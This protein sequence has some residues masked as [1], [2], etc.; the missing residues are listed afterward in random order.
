MKIIL[1]LLL[2]VPSM[3]NALEVDEKLTVRILKTSESRKTILINRGTEDGLVEGDH[4]R[5]MVTAG[6]VARGMVVKVSPSRSVWSI[7][8]LVNA[9]YIVNDSVMT[10]KITPPVKVTKDESQSLIREDVPTRTTPDSPPLGIPLADGANDLQTAGIDDDEDLRAL[11]AGG[12]S[13]RSLVERNMEVVGIVNISSLSSTSSA[14]G[15]DD[16]SGSMA[17][18]HIGATFEYYPQN[19]RAWYSRFSLLGSLNLIKS[20]AQSY[21]GFTAKNDYTEF[22]LGVNWHPTK[23]PSQVGEFIPFLTVGMGYGQVKSTVESTQ[24][25]SA[26]GTGNSFFIGGGYKFYARNGFGARI[27]LDY[28]LRSEVFDEDDETNQ[29]NRSLS[30][31][32]FQVGLSYRF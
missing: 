23:L 5:F 14:D 27:L 4:A 11:S 30:G 13:I 31:P 16:A 28:Y 1:M 24:E 20:D 26:T 25:I 6:I 22:G 12:G 2:L 15:Q 21:N 9:D 19:E 3:T 8:R 32:R 29:Y 17:Q 7:Y 18:Y 10:L